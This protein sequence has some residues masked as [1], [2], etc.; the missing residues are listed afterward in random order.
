MNTLFAIC[1]II[2]T[3]TVLVHGVNVS[4]RSLFGY[5]VDGVKGTLTAREAAHAVDA[6]VMRKAVEALDAGWTI[7]EVAAQV[8]VRVGAVVKALV[9]KV[10]R[11]V[12][13]VRQSF[14][15]GVFEAMNSMGDLGSMSP[16][17]AT[18]ANGTE[19]IVARVYAKDRVTMGDDYEAAAKVSQ[20]LRIKGH[21]V[22]AVG[23]RVQVY[24]T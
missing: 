19:M 23:N 8:V 22:V 2:H 20:A 5:A 15:T 9:A 7:V 24:A 16:W 6:I 21:R 11:T 12:K 3:A 4:R 14:F 1:S 13:V 17:L 18:S 10:A